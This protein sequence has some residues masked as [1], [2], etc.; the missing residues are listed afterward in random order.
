[1]R[2]P[3]H[4]NPTL[5]Y[6]FASILLMLGL[7]SI[8]SVSR[9]QGRYTGFYITQTARK[10]GIVTSQRAGPTFLVSPRYAYEK[11]ALP[12]L[13]TE[14]LTVQREFCER[15]RG[16][17]EELPSNISV[18]W[19]NKHTEN[20]WDLS[21]LEDFTTASEDESRAVLQKVDGVVGA[22]GSQGTFSIYIF[23]DQN[24]QSD[25]V[26][27]SL[28]DAKTWG[29]HEIDRLILQ[30]KL[31]AE[32]KNLKRSETYFIDIGSNLGYFSA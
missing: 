11:D 5:G 30:L 12:T 1:M 26:S 4:S 22:T 10:T 2:V 31:F 3:S 28:K 16:V 23:D 9:H 21:V 24:G 27:S 25:V 19:S 17:Q 15:I 29:R 20:M 13:Q 32:R 18:S 6:V 7:I 14:S 8:Y